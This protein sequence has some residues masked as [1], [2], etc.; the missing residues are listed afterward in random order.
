MSKSSAV[1]IN[2]VNRNQNIPATIVEQTAGSSGDL[3]E[4]NFSLPQYPVAQVF[5]AHAQATPR[6]SSPSPSP[7]RR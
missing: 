1:A 7:A 6:S 4:F 3:V 2:V 5:P